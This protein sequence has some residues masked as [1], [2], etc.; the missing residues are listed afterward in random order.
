M[1]EIYTRGTLKVWAG[2]GDDG[3]LRIDGQ[4]LHAS[5]EYEYFIRIAPE[6]WTLLRASLGGKEGDDLL[7]L[8]IANGRLLGTA[9][10]VSWLEAHGVPF[11]FFN[12]YEFD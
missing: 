7:E 6:H 9:G 11:E 12:R 1:K 4:D 8:V 3:Q 2:I 10:E 5:G